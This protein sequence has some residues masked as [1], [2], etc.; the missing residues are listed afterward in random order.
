MLSDEVWQLVEDHIYIIKSVI[1]KNQSWFVGGLTFDELLSFGI[2]GL[3]EASNKWAPEK[4]DAS[5]NS[6]C[7]KYIYY[8]IIDNIRQW[9][10]GGRYNIVRTTKLKSDMC[11]Q[12]DKYNLEKLDIE[13]ILDDLDDREKIVIEECVLGDTEQQSL[14]KQWNVTP[15]RIC[16]IRRKA[17]NKLKDHPSVLQYIAI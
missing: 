3:I 4:E 11:I 10:L 15:S 17:L 8:R 5:F 14:A 12:Y 13:L 2:D 7:Y 1:L 16:Q 6:F 9:N